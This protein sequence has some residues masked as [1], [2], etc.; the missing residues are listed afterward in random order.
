MPLRRA[1]SGL[2]RRQAGTGRRSSRPDAR[3]ARRGCS[4]ASTHAVSAAAAMTVA[5]ASPGGVEA[6]RT[7]A[8]KDVV[9]GLA[10]FGTG[11]SQARRDDEWRHF[12]ILPGMR[13]FPARDDADVHVIDI[14][15]HSPCRASV[16]RDPFRLAAIERPA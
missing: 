9:C 10:R 8:M 5:L 11:S 6:L 2:M 12:A 1:G 13:P 4:G 15:L 3:A 16:A 7:K 14:M